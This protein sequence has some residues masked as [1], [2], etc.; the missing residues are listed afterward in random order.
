MSYCTWLQQ[1]MPLHLARDPFTVRLF[2]LT[3]AIFRGAA[4]DAINK[5][6]LD[7]SIRSFQKTEQYKSKTTALRPEQQPDEQKQ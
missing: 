6:I 1:P 3:E 2:I 5:T 7:F 4:S